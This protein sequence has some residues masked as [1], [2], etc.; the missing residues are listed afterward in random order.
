MKFQR[1]ISFAT[2]FVAF[3]LPITYAIVGLVTVLGLRDEYS[4]VL[5]AENKDR[6]N[7]VDVF[8]CNACANS[9][10]NVVA[11]QP[12]DLPFEDA[13][14]G[15]GILCVFLPLS[16]YAYSTSLATNVGY[17][18]IL[19]NAT[20]TPSCATTG[21]Y[22]LANDFE[23]QFFA[24]LSG[25]LF[26]SLEKT[27]TKYK[28]D[29]TTIDYNPTTQSKSVRDNLNAVGIFYRS[30]IVQTYTET[31]HYSL[32]QLAAVLTQSFGF[33][34]ALFLLR[35]GT[36]TLCEFIG[37]WLKI[38]RNRHCIPTDVKTL[39]LP[40]LQRSSLEQA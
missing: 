26:I 19:V 7:L 23:Y 20:F 4:F 9:S 6:L 30:M 2:L 22:V 38:R 1:L 13:T 8:V 37:E 27:V 10:I 16:D 28:D 39:E 21:L 34:S 3:V 18:T 15:N 31:S 40:L 32:G 29:M 24:D 14:I 12:S 35:R 11:Y 36:L 17:P 5:T 25:T 33:F